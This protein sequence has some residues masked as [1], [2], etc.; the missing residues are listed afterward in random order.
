MEF[1]PDFVHDLFKI[2]FFNLKEIKFLI[3]IIKVI[4]NMHIKITTY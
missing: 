2:H 3:I 1:L 4:S